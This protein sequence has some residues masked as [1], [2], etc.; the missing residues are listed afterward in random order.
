MIPDRESQLST[1]QGQLCVVS[2][3]LAAS[4]GIYDTLYSGLWVY[5]VMS[6]SSDDSMGS[7]SPGS[8][9]VRL[10]DDV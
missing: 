6:F 3:N 7:Y 5:V 10:L 4:S 9:S 8:G 2:Q 1:V